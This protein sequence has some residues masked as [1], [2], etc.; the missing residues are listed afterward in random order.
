MLRQ[1]LRC[2]GATR[3]GARTDGDGE[4]EAREA[5]GDVRVADALRAQAARA[6]PRLPPRGAPA[7]APPRRSCVSCAPSRP[8]RPGPAAPPAEAPC[9][10]AACARAG[11]RSW[12]ERASDESAPCTRGGACR[13]KRH[14]RTSYTPSS[15]ASCSAVTPRC[16]A[17]R[18]KRER[19]V[20]RCAGA[21]KPHLPLLLP[22]QQ[23]VHVAQRL[24]VVQRVVH[25]AAMQRGVATSGPSRRCCSASGPGAGARA[26]HG[27]PAQR[28]AAPAGAAAGGGA[29]GVRAPPGRP[30]ASRLPACARADAAGRRKNYYDVLQVSKSADDASIKRS[31]RKLAVK[32]HPVRSAAAAPEAASPPACAAAAAAPSAP[33]RSRAACARSRRGACATRRVRSAA[34]VARFSHPFRAGRAPGQEPGR[35]SRHGALRGDQQRCAPAAQRIIRAAARVRRRCRPAA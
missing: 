7:S 18:S 30:A 23:L 2:H 19:S 17:W 11:K 35:R 34:C 33:Q 12:R 22:L 1:P 14:V 16:A 25:R 27:R 26:R 28:A 10:A 13:A 24:R 21:R 29:G 3:G 15:M 31:Y 9:A 4:D 20:A 8:A 6:E 32:Y 5:G